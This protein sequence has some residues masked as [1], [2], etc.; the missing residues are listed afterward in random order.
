[1][2]F[3]LA[4]PVAKMAVCLFLSLTGAQAQTLNINIFMYIKIYCITASKNL[5]LVGLTW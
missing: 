1:M 3:F 4:L 2:D 5:L